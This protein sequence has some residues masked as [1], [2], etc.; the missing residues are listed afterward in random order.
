MKHKK[1]E[2]EIRPKVGSNN[3][4]IGY[5]KRLIQQNGSIKIIGK[6]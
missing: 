4:G 5:L 1:V 6:V 3:N 2:I